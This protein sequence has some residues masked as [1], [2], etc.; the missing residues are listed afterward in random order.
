MSGVM[1]YQVSREER[2]R[3]GIRDRNDQNVLHV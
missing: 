1:E 2:A 3:E